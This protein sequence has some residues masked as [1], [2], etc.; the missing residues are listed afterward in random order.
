[1]LESWCLAPLALQDNLTDF[2]QQQA[3]LV[4]LADEFHRNQHK[5]LAWRLECYE[6]LDLRF[7]TLES[8]VTLK[9]IESGNAPMFVL[10]Q[11]ALQLLA[12]GLAEKTSG[13]IEEALAVL[14]EASKPV[15]LLALLNDSEAPITAADT[16]GL[17]NGISLDVLAKQLRQAK[18]LEDG[19]PEVLT[20]R[21][22]TFKGK[23]DIVRQLSEGICFADA[24]NYFS[25]LISHTKVSRP[26][27]LEQLRNIER[28]PWCT[29]TF[30]LEEGIAIVSEAFA[31]LD[32]PYGEKV[33]QAYAE[34]RI[35]LLKQD[36]PSMCMDTPAGSYIQLNYLNDLESLVL[37]A[38]ECG[39]LVHQE[40]VRERYGLKQ[41]ISPL[42]SE[43]IALFFEHHVA[44]YWFEKHGL[45]D[46]LAKWL[47]RQEVEWYH[48][49]RM[50]ALFEYRLYGLKV[51]TQETVT[52]LWQSINHDFYPTDVELN[53]DFLN[54]WQELAHIINSPFYNLI[55]PYAFDK[56]QEKDLKVAIRSTGPAYHS[57]TT[58]ST[59]LER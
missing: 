9:L 32:S 8:A 34:G 4:Q 26:I 25:Q 56:L 59:S 22:A 51:L 45:L 48:R 31:S 30:S 54:C 47:K 35:R 2:P 55:Y 50:L 7:D 6:V 23:E 44:C 13:F 14:T 57:T 18:R 41:D 12:E 20:Q 19:S 58:T 28:A 43:A 40:T 33:R 16:M 15:W 21:Q 39:H 52:K 24:Q 5:S 42:L 29:L 37:L 10:L 3:Q 53:H 46:V 1:M 11:E 17:V 38:H 49:H 27:S 36:E